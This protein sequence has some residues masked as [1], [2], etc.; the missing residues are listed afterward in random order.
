MSSIILISVQNSSSKQDGL[1]DPGSNFGETDIPDLKHEQPIQCFPLFMR[2]L[3]RSITLDEH[4][5]KMFKK[6]P[7]V[8]QACCIKVADAETRGFRG[9]VVFRLEKERAESIDELQQPYTSEEQKF[10]TMFWIANVSSL[11]CWS[12]SQL[13]SIVPPRATPNSDLHTLVPTQPQPENLE[14]R[15]RLL[16]LYHTDRI[17]PGCILML[18]PFKD[19]LPEYYVDPRIEPKAYNH[20]IIVVQLYGDDLFDIVIASTAPG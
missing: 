8:Q 5:R 12:L 6:W 9:V 18:P 13:S 16:G 3:P 17:E 1:E 7:S 10:S 20:P 11:Y 14:V 15:R 19:R 2:F 4:L